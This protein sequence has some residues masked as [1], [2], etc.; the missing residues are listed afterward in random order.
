MGLNMS[1]RP[2]GP[3]GT[4]KRHSRHHTAINQDAR[5]ELDELRVLAVALGVLAELGI[6]PAVDGNM[7]WGAGLEARNE[8]S[9]DG[10]A[11]SATIMGEFAV[12][13]NMTA[14]LEFFQG[15]SSIS[16]RWE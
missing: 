13:D 3:D 8:T 6:A 14:D 1:M 11:E 15:D 9:H 16:T 5:L 12:G 7:E 4:F 10:Q 2:D